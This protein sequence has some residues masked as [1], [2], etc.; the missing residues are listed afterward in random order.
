MGQMDADASG[1]QPA[2]GIFVLFIF[3][4][5]FNNGQSQDK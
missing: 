4:L 1:S 3:I 5:S 2:P